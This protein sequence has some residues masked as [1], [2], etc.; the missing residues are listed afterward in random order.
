MKEGSANSLVVRSEM[1]SRNL[2]TP[3][4][5]GKG[6]H[7]NPPGANGPTAPTDPPLLP[8]PASVGNLP[9]NLGRQPWSGDACPRPTCPFEHHQ[10][11]PSTG[12][13]G[14][15]QAQK[16]FLPSPPPPPMKLVLRSPVFV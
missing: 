1:W 9:T 3:K 2:S 10:V 15:G 11:S 6:K 12:A 7:T 14:A 13:G 8:S 5:E 4:G 16:R